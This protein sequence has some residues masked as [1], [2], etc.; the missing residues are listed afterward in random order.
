MKKTPPPYV[1]V[2]RTCNPDMSS[3]NGFKW[4]KN[5]DA[6]APDWDSTP[7]CGHGLHGHLWGHGD[8]GLLKWNEDAAWL[9]CK[10]AAKD[11]VDLN[12][13]VKFR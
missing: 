10:V 1:Y 3:H 11:I 9:V 8:P 13:K 4:P 2:L 7:E 5:G 6:K 12:G